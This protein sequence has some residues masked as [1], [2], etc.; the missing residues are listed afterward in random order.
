MPAKRELSMRQVR[1]LLRF[2]HDGGERTRDRATA[3][4][5]AQHDPGQSETGCGGWVEMAIGGR[6]LRGRS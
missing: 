5:G 3:G 6:R 1:H 4:R 2:H